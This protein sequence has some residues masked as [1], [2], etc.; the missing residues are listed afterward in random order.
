MGVGIIAVIF[1]VG[2]VR[3]DLLADIFGNG[4]AARDGAQA[5]SS[6]LAD[7]GRV[8][9]FEAWALPLTFFGLSSFM[10]GIGL[11]FWAILVEVRRRGDAARDMMVTVRGRNN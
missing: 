11:A 5:G 9:A 2:I 4:K 1:V 3:A 10:T 7:Q 8:A 6:L